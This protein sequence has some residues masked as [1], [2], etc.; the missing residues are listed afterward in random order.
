MSRTLTPAECKVRK[1]CKHP[2]G[3]AWFYAGQFRFS[4]NCDYMGDIR[5]ST[6]VLKR[7]IAEVERERKEIEKK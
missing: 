4:F 2:F 7:A 6:K 1:G 5:I 3:K